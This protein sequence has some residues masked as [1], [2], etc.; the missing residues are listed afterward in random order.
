M[1]T[2]YTQKMVP[3]KNFENLDHFLKKNSQ[4]FF[5]IFLKILDKIQNKVPKSSE[6]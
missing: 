1:S 2:I 6:C 3:E 4:F 5:I